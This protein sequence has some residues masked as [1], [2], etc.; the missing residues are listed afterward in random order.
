MEIISYPGPVPG[1]KLE[2]FEVGKRLPPVPHRNR[3]IG[4]F[5]KELRLA[6]GRNTGIPKI[7][8]TMQENGSPAPSFDFDEDR[9]YF[10]VVLPAHPRYVTMSIARE[11]AH[12]WA[13]GEREAALD[14]IQ[15]AVKAHPIAGELYAQLIDYQSILRDISQIEQ[16]A[17]IAGQTPG[18][19]NKGALWLALAQ[20]YITHN[21]SAK[22]ISAL[23]L[24][25]SEANTEINQAEIASL[26][27][28]AGDLQGAHR[29]FSIAR[30]D[31]WNDDRLLNE[32]ADVKFKI[33]KN[34]LRK[35]SRDSKGNKES[36]NRLFA[37]SIELYRRA[38]QL[39]LDPARKGWCWFRLAEI[40][41]RLRYPVNEVEH[42]YAEALQALPG[43]STISE[44]FAIWKQRNS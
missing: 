42:A 21:Q 40:Y 32:Y 44:S 20:A 22:A 3:M 15:A 36:A 43:E 23:A 31:I 13:L 12:L 41:H 16:T 10:R 29:H 24:F 17:N 26:Y 4:D 19:V 27:R 37:E 38:I 25:Q 11:S 6:E 2:H 18:L 34:L 39:S 5:L 35:W 30:Q 9:T 7:L 14:R 33:A 1:I 28:R 8:R